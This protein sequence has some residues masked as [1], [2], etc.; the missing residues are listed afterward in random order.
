MSE[1]EVDESADFLIKQIEI[2]RT[3]AK[4][5]LKCKT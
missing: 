2:A 3:K 1:R 5:Y 4:K